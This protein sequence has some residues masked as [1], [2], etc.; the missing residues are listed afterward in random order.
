LTRYGNHFAERITNRNPS[1]QM[2]TISE[3]A[4]LLRPSH[5]EV[6]T[7]SS[8]VTEIAGCFGSIYPDLAV[9]ISLDR[10][11]PQSRLAARELVDAGAFE[12]DEHGRLSVARLPMRGECRL[13][14]QALGLDHQRDD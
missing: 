9:R 4:D 7:N 14:R 6:L 3:L 2:P 1:P 8:K 12:A 10:L 13:I 11:T 5:D